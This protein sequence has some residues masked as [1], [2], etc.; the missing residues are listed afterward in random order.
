MSSVETET[1]WNLLGPSVNR[2]LQF[3]DEGW[4]SSRGVRFGL[5]STIRSGG[6]LAKE[7]D[8]TSLP[9]S[10]LVPRRLRD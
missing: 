6:R 7:E 3:R 1:E 8:Q 2:G 10:V 5:E 4:T 9:K